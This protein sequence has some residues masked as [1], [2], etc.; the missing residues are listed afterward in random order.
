[1]LS[2]TLACLVVVAHA[3]GIHAG[4]DRRGPVVPTPASVVAPEQS[5]PLTDTRGLIAQDLTMDTADFLGRKAVRLVKTRESGVDG[6][7]P[8]AGVDFRMGPSK[9][10]W[11]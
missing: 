8:L 1:M 10:T 7:V 11:R 3:A 9:P 4:G 6:F 5:S 2:V